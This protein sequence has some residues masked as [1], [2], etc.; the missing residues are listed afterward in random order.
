MQ[1]IICSN[2]IIS[3]VLPEINTISQIFN[4]FHQMTSLL[5]MG[6]RR[7]MKIVYSNMTLTFFPSSAQK[8]APCENL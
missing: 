1:C 6:L 3:E 8:A 5:F 4:S 7:V 2:E